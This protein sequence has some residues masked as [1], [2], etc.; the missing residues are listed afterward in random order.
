MAFSSMNS[1]PEIYFDTSSRREI[2]TAD[3]DEALMVIAREVRFEPDH[4]SEGRSEGSAA[5]L[6]VGLEARVRNF[7]RCGRTRHTAA[8]S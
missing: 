1:R 5:Q 4:A 3:S 2:P 8:E 6:Y 7:I